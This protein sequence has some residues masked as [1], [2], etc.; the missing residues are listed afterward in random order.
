L[1]PALAGVWLSTWP[2]FHAPAEWWSEGLSLDDP[3]EK[4]FFGWVDGDFPEWVYFS[5][6]E[7]AFAEVRSVQ[8]MWDEDFKPVRFADLPREEGGE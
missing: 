8:V 1:A 3:S 6:L 4:I 5:L 7:M 2:G